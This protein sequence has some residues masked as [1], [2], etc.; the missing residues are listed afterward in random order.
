MGKGAS[1][2]IPKKELKN[3]IKE[4]KSR[5]QL[6]KHY[7]CSVA[8]LSQRIKDYNLL[9]KRLVNTSKKKVEAF[10]ARIAFQRAEQIFK[11]VSKYEVTMQNTLTDLTGIA[12]IL[13]QK[14]I[15]SGKGD[16]L[17]QDMRLLKDICD[18]IGSTF[19]KFVRLQDDIFESRKNLMFREQV[20]ELIE[21]E[22]PQLF[23]KLYSETQLIQS[24]INRIQ[25]DAFR[26]SGEDALAVIRQV[27]SEVSSANNPD[28]K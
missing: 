8:T 22:A 19:E 14:I 6:A 20:R 10:T 12:L 11:D 24:A 21:R 5:K 27:R 16:K 7:H 4:G 9:K 3:L 2:Y 25:P 1:V 13:K 28:G 15:D 18:S 26:R 23:A 17:P